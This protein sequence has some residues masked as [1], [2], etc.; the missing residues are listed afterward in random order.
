MQ[1]V[2]PFEKLKLAGFNNL[3][4]ALSF[5]IYDFC[6]ADTDAERTAYVDYINTKYNANKITSVLRGICDIIEANVL[7]VSD[8]D[9]EP[10]GASSLVLMS[11]IKGGGLDSNAMAKDLKGKSTAMHLDKSHICAH[12]YP[13]FL[14]KGQICSVR[15]D[16]DIATCGEISPL[17]ALNYMFKQ[18]ESDVVVIDYVVRGYTRDEEG[19]RVYMDHP[20]NSIRD[21]IDES[22]LEDYYSLDLAL[23]RDLIWQTKMLR[24]NLKEQDYFLNP[25]DLDDPIIR[26]KIDA[27]KREM[28][29]VL[30]MFPE[31]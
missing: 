25:V 6:T 30:H 2:K 11:D 14:H 15:V 10:W 12:T 5:N 21:Y 13:D 16:I 1:R 17:N 28:R 22:I 4:K 20:L 24:T 3:T 31:N 7:A 27:V 23:Q 9:Y 19:R 18:F 8:Q 26:Q 29:G